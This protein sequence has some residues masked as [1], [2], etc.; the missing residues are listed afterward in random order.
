M[1][2]LCS[3]FIILASIVE[4]SQLF[5]LNFCIDIFFI[6][7]SRVPIGNMLGL[8]YYS[9]LNR[10]WFFF[11]WYCGLNSVPFSYFQNRLPC[12]LDHDTLC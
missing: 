10:Y 5:S 1:F 2:S 8:I 11:C 4:S 9:C 6:I 7:L 12:S 3:G